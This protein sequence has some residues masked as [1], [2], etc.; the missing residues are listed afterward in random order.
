MTGRVRGVNYAPVA[1]PAFARQVITQI[2]GVAREW[3]ALSDQPFDCLAA[4]FDHVASG[5]GVAKA[6]SGY[7]RVAYVVLRAIVLRQDRR[8]SALRPVR[9]TV[10]QCAFCKN[11]HLAVICKV[12]RNRE[13]GKATSHDRDVESLHKYLS[14]LKRGSVPQWRCRKS[15]ATTHFVAMN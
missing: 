11:S 13:A 10:Q 7:F 3:H 1:V 12:K 5:R 6:G 8:N 4:V 14:G 9:R 2:T 15:S